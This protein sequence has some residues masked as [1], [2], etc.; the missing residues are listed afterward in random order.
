MMSIA[1]KTFKT[2]NRI[3][4]EDAKRALS[5]CQTVARNINFVTVRLTVKTFSVFTTSG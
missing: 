5:K 3:Y 4:R 1:L 2:C